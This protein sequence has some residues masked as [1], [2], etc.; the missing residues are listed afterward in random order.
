MK[1]QLLLLVKKEDRQQNVQLLNKVSLHLPMHASV[2]KDKYVGFLPT[3]V[4]KLMLCILKTDKEILLFSN[5]PK[6]E[7]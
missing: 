3:S 2:Q 6:L 7:T 1:W 5:T 4:T